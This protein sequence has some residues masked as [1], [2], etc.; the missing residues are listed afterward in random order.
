MSELDTNIEPDTRFLKN[1]TMLESKRRQNTGYKKFGLMIKKIQR[2]I[3]DTVWAD[4]PLQTLQI[5][6]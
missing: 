2:D 4:W 3:Q 1:Y 6:E 5:E